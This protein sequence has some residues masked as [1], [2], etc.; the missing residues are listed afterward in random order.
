M[1]LGLVKR[2]YWSN[3]YIFFK[4]VS[5]DVDKPLLIWL[6]TSK[7]A[8]TSCRDSVTAFWMAGISSKCDLSGFSWTF[9]TGNS[10]QDHIRAVHWL[11]QSCNI[12]L[13][14]VGR[15][16]NGSVGCSAAMVKF[17]VISILQSFPFYGQVQ[18]YKDFFVGAD[19]DAFTSQR[20]KFFW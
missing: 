20:Y 10:L 1:R 8:I 17:P 12:Y 19:I 18:A 6:H 2:I 15:H 7:A 11:Q 3:W 9:K 5:L 16:N 14:Q 4:T 13:A